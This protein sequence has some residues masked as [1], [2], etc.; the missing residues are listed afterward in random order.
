LSSTILRLA[1]A[2]YKIG[3]LDFFHAPPQAQIEAAT[4]ELRLFGFLSED[5]TL[6]VQGQAAVE[7]VLQVADCL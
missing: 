4:R 2:G 6:T 1:G 5:G 3:D 7:V